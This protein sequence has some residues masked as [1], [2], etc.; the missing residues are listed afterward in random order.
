MVRLSMT[1]LFVLFLTGCAGSAYK[2]PQVT[3]ADMQ[4]MEKK[5]ADNKQPLKIYKRSDRQYT[6]RL[7]GISRRLG[8]NARPLCEHAEYHSCYFQVIYDPDDTVNAYASEGHKITVYRG[9]LQYLK[10]D[11]EMAA[12]VA[13]EMGHHL[14]NHNEETMQNAAAGAV[15]SGLLTAVLLGAANANNPYY[16]TSYQQQQQRKT[17]ED[18]MRVGAEI[19]V[20]SY[21]KE[22]EREADLLATYLL[23]RA[24][25]NLGRA[26]NIMLVLAN[27][28]GEKRADRAAFLDTHPAGT[29]RFVAWEKAMEEVAA[30][31]TKLPY[32]KEET[33]KARNS[34]QTEP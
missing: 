26:Q 29:E 14:A 20:L 13:H 15:V 12:V 24:G 23:S 31:T 19:G 2:L 30:N 33:L 5:I 25:Y 8:K 3:D 21:S 18:M 11:D 16:N 9:L 10:N 17:I 6:E 7:A 34:G 32:R 22:Q 4:A 27:F 1:W 28:S